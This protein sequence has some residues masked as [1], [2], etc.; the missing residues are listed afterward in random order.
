MVPLPVFNNKRKVFIMFTK[1]SSIVAVL[2]LIVA[3]VFAAAPSDG[4]N[5]AIYEWGV[6]T[7][8][9]STANKDT[10]AGDG[11][12][13]II[14]SAFSPEQGHEYIYVRDAHTGGGSDSAYYSVIVRSY[15]AAG[16]LLY[17]V[18]IDTA[19]TAAGEAIKI[20]FGETLIG[21]KFKIVAKGITGG[22]GGVVIFNR[23]YIYTRRPVVV[24]KAWR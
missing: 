14:Q 22:T 20:P 9:S 18:P 2:L 19:L 5:D 15:D 3:G 21:N 6:K 24:Q 13:V 16:N 4:I 1:S 8:I 17:S 7:T 11:D 12:S 23:S 10:L